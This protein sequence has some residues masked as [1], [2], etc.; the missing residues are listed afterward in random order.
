VGLSQGMCVHSSD[1]IPTPGNRKICCD[2]NEC[3]CHFRDLT[4]FLDQWLASD[5]SLTIAFP[6]VSHSILKTDLQTN[7]IFVSYDQYTKVSKKFVTSPPLLSCRD[8]DCQSTRKKERGG[9]S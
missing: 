9:R 6:L 8:M 1:I 7:Q 4:D 3:D 5:R 2:L